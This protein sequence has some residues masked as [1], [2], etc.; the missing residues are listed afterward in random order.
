MNF[1]ASTN[2]ICGWCRS[3][4]LYHVLIHVPMHASKDSFEVFSACVDFQ[5]VKPWTGV[6]FHVGYS[7]GHF[8]CLPLVPCF[9]C[10]IKV[11]KFHGFVT[12]YQ[13]SAH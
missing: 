6:R 12:I 1:L 9:I 8:L 2:C 13:S 3:R 11:C 10:N 5:W 7:F 4:D